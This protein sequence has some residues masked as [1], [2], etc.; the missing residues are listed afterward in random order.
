ME[1]D[2]AGDQSAV[3]ITDDAVLR[4]GELIRSV[5]GASAAELTPDALVAELETR[6]GHGK[7]AWPLS[8]IRRLADVLLDV[9]AGRG[10]GASYEARWLNLAGF[11]VRPGF[12][13]ASDA[14]RVS[15]LRKVY[16]TGL[17]FPK[18]IQNQVE[19]LVLWQRVAA[20]FNT[21]QQRELAQRITGALGLGQR[22]RPRLN[23]QIERESWRLLASLERLDAG[24]RTKL[25]NE[26]IDRIRR[27]PRSTTWLWS[28]GRLGARVPLYGPLNT[29]VAPSVAERWIDGLLA[30][31]DLT[32]ESAAAIAEIGARTDDPARDLSPEAVGRTAARL[33]AAGYAPL[34]E[35]LQQVRP[36]ERR[37][38]AR[39]FGESLPEG[40]RLE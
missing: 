12:G 39:V 2:T 3:V 15:E 32:G 35:Q 24:Q 29:V 28:L 11:C 4:G 27:E 5:F 38:S 1:A 31:K 13:S 10:K 7:Q 20:G 14:F 25:G 18:E 34:V 23:P 26:L 30:L 16:M 40:L 19:W 22:K 17:L 6:L 21:G 37:D 9:A 36:P 33:E 8:A